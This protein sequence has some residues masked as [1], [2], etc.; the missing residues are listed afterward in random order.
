MNLRI[1]PADA[2]AHGHSTF[3]VEDSLSNDTRENGSTERPVYAFAEVAT[4][5][6]TNNVFEQQTQFGRP[7]HQDDIMIFNVCVGDPE[8]VAYLIDLYTYSSRVSPDDDEPPYHLG[9]HYILPNVLRKSDGKIEM[10]ITC[11]SKHRPL[12]MMNIEYI[13]VN[14]TIFFK[15]SYILLMQL[16]IFLKKKIDFTIEFIGSTEYETIVLSLLEQTM[17][18]F[19]SGSSWIW[20]KF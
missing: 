6:S 7:Y 3:D 9:Y 15:I 20:H 12:G 19:G 5:K 8:N 13:R 16:Y 10:P 4:L 18:R 11:A 1:N 2:S 14:S 17:E